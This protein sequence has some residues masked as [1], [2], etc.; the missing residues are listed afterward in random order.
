[1]RGTSSLE[2]PIEIR[3]SNPQESARSGIALLTLIALACLTLETELIQQI[4]SL[5][6]YL[7]AREIL[8][9]AAIALLYS[10]VTAVCWWLVVLLLGEVVGIFTSAKKLLPRLVWILWMGVPLAYFLLDLFEDL[11]IE[12]R[13][14]WHAGTGLQFG[15]AF[16][17]TGVCVT[18]LSLV[19]WHLLQHFCRTRMVPIAWAHLALAL[20]GSVPLWSYGI[21]PFHDYERGSDT[22]AAVD[23]PNIYLITIDALRADGMSVYGYSR[24]TTPYLDKL[25]QR[26]FTFDYNFAN[27]NFT[28]PATASIETGKIPWSHGIYQGGGFLRGENKEETLAATLKDRGYYTAMVTSNLLAAPFRHRTLESYDATE[29]ATPSG[30]TGLRMTASNFLNSNAQFTLNFSLLRFA[31]PLATGLDRI[32]LGAN[33]PSP[34]EEVFARAEKLVATHESVHHPVF[35]WTHI[36]PPHDPYWVPTAYQRHFVSQ[37]TTDYGKFMV[38]DPKNVKR[39][40]TVQQLR[41][42]Y[43]EMVLYADY[44][45][46]EFL[47]WL[48]QTGRLDPSI[49]I[50]S[51]DHGELFDH[52]RLAHGGL[53]LY[54]GVIRVPLLI[55]LPGQSKTVRVETA[56]QQADLLATV[57]DLIGS[58]VPKWTDGRSLKPL[59]EGANVGDRYIFSMNLEP[60]RS[61]DPITKGAIAVIDDQYKYVRHMQSGKEELFQYRTD[62]AE[63]RNLSQSDPEVAGRMRGVLLK[64]LQEVNGWYGLRQ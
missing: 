38:P 55:H 49:V 48:D 23:L 22:N 3:S 57:L 51:S 13:P 44:S 42:A 7:T 43:D 36:F 59:M 61:F 47:A 8:I 31:N 11:K 14:E 33:Y 20:L 46:G 64:K 32:F 15:T 45:V 41:D 18:S 60:N 1:M 40:L 27:S 6:L 37:G 10:V 54:N 53:D 34:A 9:E 56:S 25:A 5:R 12:F 17:I 4:D 30:L 29:Y 50:I 21:R 52:G 26:S 39:G 24:K 2:L 62:A 19:D 16:L 35:L 63:E 58:P 28:T